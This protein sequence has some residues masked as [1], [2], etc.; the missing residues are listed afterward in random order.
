MEKLIDNEGIIK[1]IPNATQELAKIS[2]EYSK[3]E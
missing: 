1:D 3:K 2:S